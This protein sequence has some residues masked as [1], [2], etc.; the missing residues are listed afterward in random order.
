MQKG[1]TLKKPPQRCIGMK[2]NSRF[3]ISADETAR[4]FTSRAYT[5][6]GSNS[7]MRRIFPEQPEQY[8]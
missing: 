6:G 2:R 5:G 1:P 7:Q 8:D 3:G 4:L